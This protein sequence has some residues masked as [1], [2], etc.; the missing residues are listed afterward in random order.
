MPL[1]LTKIYNA[2]LDIVAMGE[3]QRTVSL[4]GVFRRDFED[5]SPKFQEKPVYPT[6]QN[7]GEVPMDTLFRHLTTEII[8][9]KTRKRCFEIER[10]KR[11]HWV[12]H[13]LDQKKAD[14]MRLFSVQEREGI[15]TYY[16]DKDENYVIVLEPLRDGK[17][18]YLLTAYYIQGK[19]AQRNK[20]EKKYKRRLEEVL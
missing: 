18:Y 17:S 2:L 8:D 6:P 5:T 4:K 16:Y 13:H 1:N 14:N 11:L 20:M 10:S 12:R 3:Q 15:R 19:D 7:N 9:Y